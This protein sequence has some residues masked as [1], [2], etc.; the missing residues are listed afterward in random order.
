VA[1][2]YNEIML[3]R[4]RL[5]EMGIENPY[6]GMEIPMEFV[7]G[8]YMGNEFGE[9]YGETF[10]LSAMYTEFVSLHPGRSGTPIFVSEAFAERHGLLNYDTMDVRVIFTNQGRAVEYTKRLAQDL[11]LEYE[12]EIVVHPA[13]KYQRDTGTSTMYIAISIIVTFFSS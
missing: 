3:S 10:I 2:A 4:A 5:E 7:A 8:D 12:R 9:R 1:T 6:I 13:L 11:G